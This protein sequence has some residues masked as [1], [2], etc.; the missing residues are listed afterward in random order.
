MKALGV[1][2]SNWDPIRKKFARRLIEEQN[3]VLRSYFAQGPNLD[4]VGSIV[5]VGVT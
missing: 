5:I 2:E 3:K 4:Y 1:L